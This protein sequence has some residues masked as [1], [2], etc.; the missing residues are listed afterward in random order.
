MDVSRLAMISGFVQYDASLPKVRIENNK[1]KYNILSQQAG[2][3]T[4]NEL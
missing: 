3:F 4:V 1:R 2:R